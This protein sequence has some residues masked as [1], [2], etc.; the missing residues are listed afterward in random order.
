MLPARVLIV[1]VNYRTPQLALD[2]VASLEAEVAARGDTHVVVVENGSDDGSAGAIAA[3]LAERGFGA[4]CTLHAVT[5]NGGFAAGNNAALDWYRAQN[6]GALP[7]FVWLLNPDTRAEPDALGALM[8]FLETHGEVGIAGGAI[9]TEEG[10]PE[11]SGFTFHSPF[12]DLLSALRL[13]PLFRLFPRRWVYLPV[14]RRAEPVDWVSGAT[15][16]IRRAVIE[17]IGP[18]DE[19]YFL[20]FEETDYCARAADA[21]FST[22]IVPESRIVHLAGASTGMTRQRAP[23]RPR[24]WF[25]ARARFYIRRY[26]L[27][28][29]NLANIGWL[30]LYPL[31]FVLARL[32]GF[33]IADPPH[34]WRDFLMAYYGPR[35]LMYRGR[36]LAA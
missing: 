31:G 14:A 2:A 33:P 7:E 5:R 3:G 32:R 26:G 22:W 6:G 9:L 18:M 24:Y 4:W 21:G 12:G 25:A 29:A 8:R 15:F 17:R 35:G 27:A 1:I 19:G 34:F 11:P 13:G 28:R 23:R 10:E 36:T 20:Y 16:L 30:L